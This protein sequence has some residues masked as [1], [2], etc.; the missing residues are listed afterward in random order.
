MPFVSKP[1]IYFN[2]TPNTT[3]M[4]GEATFNL[5]VNELNS[6]DPVVSIDRTVTL[7]IQTHPDPSKKNLINIKI[8]IPLKAGDTLT[9]N[10]H[11]LRK[12]LDQI[13]SILSLY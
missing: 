8:D 11:D 10:R 5:K 9:V 7:S 1:K 6:A 3:T 4:L 12:I 2:I 13:E